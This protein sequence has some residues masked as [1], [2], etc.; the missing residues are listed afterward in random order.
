M[1]LLKP[2]ETGSAGS[3]QVQKRSCPD[4]LGP[5]VVSAKLLW[6]SVDLQVS[7]SPVQHINNA[8]NTNRRLLTEG[9]SCSMQRGAK[10]TRNENPADAVRGAAVRAAERRRVAAELD[11]GDQAG[12]SGSAA[13]QRQP[14]ATRQPSAAA[15]PVPLPAIYDSDASVV[16]ADADDSDAST[17][18]LSAAA[19]LAGLGQVAERADDDDEVIDLLSATDS[20][21]E[22]QVVDSPGELLHS[23]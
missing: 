17:V 14:A 1:Q 19:Q 6:L 7:L 10:R 18:P 20:D 22:V 8:S 23:P 3:S 15:L 12:A 5:R 2:G 11:A 4:E 21:D 9:T 16:P 13:S